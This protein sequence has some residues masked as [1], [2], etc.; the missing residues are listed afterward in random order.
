MRA[1]SAGHDGKHQ[2]V[3]F[4]LNYPHLRILYLPYHVPLV[5]NYSYCANITS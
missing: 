3:I 1:Y 2:I 5:F 4:N